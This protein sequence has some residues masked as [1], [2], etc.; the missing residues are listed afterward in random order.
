MATSISHR[1]DDLL[2]RMTLDEKLAQ[3]TSCWMYELLTDRALDPKKIAVRL[4]HGIGQITR[5]GGGSGMPPEKVARMVNQIQRFLVEQTRLGIPA[6]PHEESC[7]G[8]LVLGGTMFPQPI[9]VA[10]TFQPEL[11]EEMARAIRRQLLAIGARQALAPVL[12]LAR[13]PRWGRVEE[14]YGEDPT[15]A[16]HFGIAYVRGL[17]GEDLRQGVMA[18]G[19]HFVGHSASQGGLNCG[20]VH[21]G[22]YELHD[23]Y[24]T[25]FH[26]A[27]QEANLASIMNAYPELDGEVVAASRHLLTHLLR[28]RLG[29]DGLVVSD[30]DA[31]SMI[32]S[33]HFVAP[34][35]S[36][37]AVLAL[38]AGIEVELP[39][40]TAYGDPL[41]AALEAGA[42]DMEIVDQAVRRHLQ[43]KFE[44]GLF[45][46][47]YVDEKRAA[48]VFD[49]PQDRALA[50]EIARRSLVLLKN[51]G[52][53]PLSRS[54]R[55]LAVIG[56]NAHQW[57]NLLGDYSYVAHY[58]LVAHLIGTTPES[59]AEFREKGVHVVSVLEGIRALA[60][61]ETRILYA[62][63]CDNLD[64]DTQG[65]AEAVR[66]A[67]ESDAVVLVL[68]DRSGLK[69][70]CTCGETRDSASLRLPGAQ[71]ELARAILDTG[72]PVVVVLVTG[73]PY[74]I[75]DLASRANAILQAWLPGEEGGTAIAEALFGDF[76]P[77]GRLPIAFP[78]SVG[79][80]PIFYN[81][82][83]SGGRSNWYRDYV[84]ESV[85]PLYPF[86]HGLSYTT[87]AYEN[88]TISPTQATAGETVEIAVDVINTGSRQGEEVVQ[89]Y[90][91]DEFASLPRPVKE[92][93][94]YIR[95]A[96]EPGER[97]Q[98]TFHLPVNQL[99]FY[100]SNLQ[101]VLEPGTIQVMVGSSS[102]AIHLQGSFEIVG[103]SNKTVERRVFTCP[104]TVQ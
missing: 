31:I 104:V 13:D 12:D 48:E 63:G 46:N 7:C 24:L 95:L 3:L 45:D 61:P 87:F 80:V 6:L 91:R 73:R 77:G 14:T 55:S 11:A 39:T 64:P 23:L 59:E 32:H 103:S 28:E 79:Q 53:L 100:D 83:P 16:A 101:L 58:E 102:T 84:D 19:K 94:G 68:G 86:G 10:S 76:N 1:I 92:L 81:H 72:K 38:Q 44:L 96:L 57:R 41:R 50:R 89:L 93:K 30:Y 67:E 99:A 85:E 27:I 5:P 21:L 15:L 40:S 49:T 82:K 4:K 43:K 75:T 70:D 78:R 9:G 34:N 56:P 74:A 20:P 25:P 17:Q 42:L 98:V 33:Y 51:D 69:P 47:P 2:A 97:K 52:L 36:A 60:S 66:L 62:P 88:L 90:T 37:A 22:W 65:I 35:M 71:H 8:A 29:F 54:L 18:T 26:A